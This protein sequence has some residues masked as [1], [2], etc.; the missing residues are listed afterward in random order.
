MTADFLPPSATAIRDEDAIALFQ[1]LHQRVVQIPFESGAEILTSYIHA[2]PESFRAAPIVLLS[3]FDSSLLEFRRLFPRLATQHETWAIDL[4]GFGFTQVI[5][6][7][8]VNPTFIRHHLL[9]IVQTWI[10]QPVILVSGCIVG[11]CSGD[12]LRL[13]SS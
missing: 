13:A 11:R 12:R 8:S 3:G 6:P 4:L 1:Q 5:P 7:V 9:K 10:D 2:A